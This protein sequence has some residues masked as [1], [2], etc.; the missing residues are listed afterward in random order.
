MQ[1]LIDIIVAVVRQQIGYFDRGDAPAWDFVIGDFT[2][3]GTWHDLTLPTCVPLN[4]RLVLLNVQV[5][6]TAVNKSVFFASADYSNDFN[7]SQNW[8]QS[9]NIRIGQDF[10]VR[11][12]PGT[13]DI[14]YLMSITGL[15]LVN[16][17]VRGWWL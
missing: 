8:T 13:R 4:A 16:V 9:I 3:D 11:P 17:V 15:S 14:R 10:K 7:L 6:A 5:R 2:K 12:N 1:W